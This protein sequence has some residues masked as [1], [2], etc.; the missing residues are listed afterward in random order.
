[1]DATQVLQ[2][3]RVVPVVVINTQTG[4]IETPPDIITRGFLTGD[5]TEQLLSEARD[6]V[7]STLENSSVEEV[8]DSGLV[9]EKISTELR[10][11]FRKR[12]QRRPM[13][14]PV[15]MEI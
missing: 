15:V 11:F 7:V 1:M 12:T 14:L 5:D 6:L 8:T 4:N 9:K 3:F 2:Q 10:R 13:I